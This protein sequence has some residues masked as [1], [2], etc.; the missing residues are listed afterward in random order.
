M[1][2]V[3]RLRVLAVA[4]FAHHRLGETVQGHI[5]N[6]Q[7]GLNALPNVSCRCSRKA[8]GAAA[9]R[10]IQIVPKCLRAEYPADAVAKDQCRNDLQRRKHAHIR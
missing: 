4:P 3:Q 10:I 1:R 5:G 9:P 6:G 2:H 8:S 7:Q